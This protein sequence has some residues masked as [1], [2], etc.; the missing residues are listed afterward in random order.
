MNKMEELRVEKMMRLGCVACAYFNVVYPA[1][2]CHH[3]LYGNQR[4]GDWFTIPLCRG[5]HQGDWSE[6]QKEVFAP[7]L[8][9]SIASGRKAFTRV[10][11][12]E[13]DL[14]KSVQDRLGLSW[15]APKGV[16]RIVA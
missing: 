8:R 1:Q 6:D 3:I 10:Y 16:T 2:E 4:M 15:P 9:V 13:H 5:H 11:P 12:T 14:W 7:H